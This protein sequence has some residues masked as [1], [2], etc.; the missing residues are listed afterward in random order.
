MKKIGLLWNVVTSPRTTIIGLI[1]SFSAGAALLF[2]L[3][4][5]GCD[6][7]KLTFDVLGEAAA[8]CA[9]PAVAGGVMQ[10]KKRTEGD[11]EHDK[12]GMGI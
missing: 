12:N 2:L 8:I 11:D 10:D 6:L 7:S 9:A 3:N 4:A 1:G 5:M